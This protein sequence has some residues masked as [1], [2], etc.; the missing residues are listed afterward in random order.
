MFCVRACAL[1]RRAPCT[2]DYGSADLG[3]RIGDQIQTRW[4]AAVGGGEVD[5]VLRLLRYK[6]SPS[7]QDAT[8]LLDKAVRRG[9]AGKLR[10][11]VAALRSGDVWSRQDEVGADALYW[12]CK[13]GDSHAARVLVTS[14]CNVDW[15]QTPDGATLAFTA[16]FNGHTDALRELISAK[17]DVDKARNDDGATPAYTAAFTGHKD[18]LRELISAKCDV[19]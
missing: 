5:Y 1:V 12:A 14:S 17:C 15:R 11:V 4:T 3:T 2:A 18:A 7:S 10:A 16:A 9:R 8:A 19:D 13:T 6:A